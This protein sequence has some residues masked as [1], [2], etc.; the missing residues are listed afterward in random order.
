VNNDLLSKVGSNIGS[1]A[2]TMAAANDVQNQVNEMKDV[3][4]Q[5]QKEDDRIREHMNL[6]INNLKHNIERIG[7]QGGSD[8]TELSKRVASLEGRV[9]S[10]S[11]SSSS[12]SSSG[13]GSGK[14]VL[15]NKLESLLDNIRNNLSNMSS[16]EVFNQLIELY[17]NNR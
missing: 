9:S 2:D 6:Q 13:G 11:S 1:I 12:G 7:S 17:N 10:L 3:I 5:M 16:T 14:T 4:N 8:I 15:M